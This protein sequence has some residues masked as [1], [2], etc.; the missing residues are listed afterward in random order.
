[1]SIIKRE[2]SQ[3]IVSHFERLISRGVQNIMS[4]FV[5]KTTPVDGLTP[6]EDRASADT[7][8]DQL[9]ATLTYTEP[10][11]EAIRSGKY[12]NLPYGV[13]ITPII[14]LPRSVPEWRYTMPAVGKCGRLD[15]LVF[16]VCFVLSLGLACLILEPIINMWVWPTWT[17]KRYE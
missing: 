9:A 14:L 10:M 8:T 1:M 13:S 6:L 15:K 11:L 2:L 3:Q 5:A 16:K 4:K 7:V 12:E 17:R